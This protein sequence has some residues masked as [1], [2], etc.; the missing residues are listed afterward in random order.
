MLF[1]LV[2]IQ[3]LT[4]FCTVCFFTRLLFTKAFVIQGLSLTRFL[5]F[6]TNGKFL[7]NSEVKLLLNSPV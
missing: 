5:D 4:I 6:L 2:L 7:L 3:L 1:H